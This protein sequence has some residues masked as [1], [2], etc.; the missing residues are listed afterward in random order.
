VT[1]T[2]IF[3]KAVGVVTCACDIMAMVET[4]AVRIAGLPGVASS[5]LPNVSQLKIPVITDSQYVGG[6][7]AP[8]SV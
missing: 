7:Y 1:F 8:Y 5:E 2:S 3:G 4:A 6:F